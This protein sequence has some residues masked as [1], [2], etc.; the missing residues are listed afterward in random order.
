MSDLLPGDAGYVFAAYMIFFALLL[1]YLGILG[2]KFQRINRELAEL[3]EEV[4]ESGKSKATETA[5]PVGA[6]GPSGV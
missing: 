3:N 1:V 6:E 2:A 5:E 4:R